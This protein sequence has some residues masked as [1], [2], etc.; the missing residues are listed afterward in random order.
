MKKIS[1]LLIAL[2]LTFLI[3]IEPAKANQE[4][5]SELVKKDASAFCGASAFIPFDAGTN[6]KGINFV[7]RSAVSATGWK[8][9]TG[10]S[11]KGSKIVMPVE[12]FRDYGYCHIFD[13]HMKYANTK[14]ENEVKING[15]WKSQF[16]YAQF[17]STAMETAMEV[18]NGTDELEPDTEK[19]N[20]FT[21]TFFS[22]NEKQRVR[23]VLQRGSTWGGYN[24]YDW[25][26]VSMYPV[27]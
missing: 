17:P 18:I 3:G 10:K 20:R 27:F 7:Q 26:I 21:K 6:T 14:T 25:V 1:G 19:A 8:D 13:K 11:A 23:V 2:F 12:K 4:L 24:S 9:Q 16:Q 22:Y 5:L 15:A